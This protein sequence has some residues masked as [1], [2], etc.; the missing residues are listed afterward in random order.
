MPASPCDYMDEVNSALGIDMDT[1]DVQPVLDAAV[2]EVVRLK[3]VEAAFR[4]KHQPKMDRMLYLV[5]P[6]ADQLDYDEDGPVSKDLFVYATDPAEAIRLWREYYE[7][8][9]EPD[10]Q[11]GVGPTH[12]RV[13]EVP[14]MPPL[15][16][17]TAVGWSDIHE[18]DANTTGSGQR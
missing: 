15:C 8:D 2:T 12:V 4:A 18:F 9:D 3:R 10:N 6:E 7:L 17:S 5:A 1:E 13:F 11:L 14:I 16:E